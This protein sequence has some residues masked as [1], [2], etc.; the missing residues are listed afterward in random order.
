VNENVGS[1]GAVPSPADGRAS[2]V[3]SALIPLVVG[4]VA[5]VAFVGPAL[6]LVL[7]PFDWAPEEGLAL[8]YA[9]RFGSSPETLYPSSGTAVPFP[10]AYTPLFPLLLAPVLDLFAAPFVGPRL[11][12]CALLVCL[13]IVLRQLIGGTQ[14]T[15]LLAI[16]FAFTNGKMF[17]YLAI[18]R[19]DLPMIVGAF[20]FLLVVLPA[21]IDARDERIT[22][23]RAA[24]ASAILALAMLTKPTAVVY[25]LPACAAWLVIDRPSAA[26]LATAC[27][28]ALVAVFVGLELVT[29]GGFGKTMS[30]WGTHPSLPHRVQTILTTTIAYAWPTLVPV[31]VILAV[32]GPLRRALLKDGAVLIALGA[33]TVLPL[34]L[35]AG[36]FYTY[37]IPPL[38][39]VAVWIGRALSLLP[40][41]RARR[42]AEGAVLV[43]ALFCLFARQL[44]LPDDDDLKTAQAFFGFIE[45][46]TSTSDAPIIATRPD[47]AYVVADH[48]TEIEGSGF[49]HLVRAKKPGLDDVIA[50]VA[51]QEYALIVADTVFYA[52]VPELLV[53]TRDHY[54]AVA[55]CALDS[56]NGLTLVY[57]FLP[58]GGERPLF[59]TGK[60]IRC[61]KNPPLPP[62]FC[63][64]FTEAP[65]C[66]STR[67]VDDT[68]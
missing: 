34:V 59:P 35:K 42:S 14:R 45:T 55:A 7:Y 27:T 20:A 61:Q 58:Q 15:A 10:L 49:M 2:R 6:T 16:A 13:V 38:L 23:R 36:A 37:F 30:L 32:A 47:F 53:S 21:A 11:V 64:V 29:D 1:S 22:W 25:V 28:I 26:R 54:E 12:V 63:S 39:G 31:V 40:T 48:P 46:V 62:S 66:A 65:G 67:T 8:D 56:V 51:R 4:V 68:R 50:R 43:M 17:A 5:L 3:T 52:A 18:V 33:F 60:G 19:V 44:P 57:V 9:R 24:L 41:T